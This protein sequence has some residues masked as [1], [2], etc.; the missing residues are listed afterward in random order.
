MSN[1]FDFLPEELNTIILYYLNDNNDLL[2]VYASEVLDKILTD[3]LFWL[4]KYLFNFPRIDPNMIKNVYHGYYSFSGAMNKRKICELLLNY[5]IFDLV[6]EYTENIFIDRLDPRFSYELIFEVKD[7]SNIK[8]IKFDETQL[9]RIIKSGMR[10]TYLTFRIIK[11]S[12]EYDN[13][14][15]NLRTALEEQGIPKAHLTVELSTEIE[16]LKIIDNKVLENRELFSL[17]FDLE[18]NGFEY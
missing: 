16:K 3:Q 5:K 8:I 10:L 9:E 6:Y 11:E 7:I 17:L 13:R 18:L 15:E 12:I 2:N 14:I 4:N 1:Y